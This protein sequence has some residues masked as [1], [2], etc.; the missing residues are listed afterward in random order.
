M[1]DIELFKMSGL[2]AGTITILFLLYKLLKSTV[3]KRFISNCCGKKMEVGLEVREIHR[4]P[5]TPSVEETRLEI[6]S[7]PMVEN[8][9]TS[10]SQ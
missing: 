1:N 7:N 4:S 5:S 6:K 3:G 8:A 9:R 2:S 10:G